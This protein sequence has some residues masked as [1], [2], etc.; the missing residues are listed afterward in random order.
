LSLEERDR[1]Y[2][3]DRVIGH[4]DELWNAVKERSTTPSSAGSHDE[5]KLAL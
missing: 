2:E 5:T 1:T 3:P 4:F